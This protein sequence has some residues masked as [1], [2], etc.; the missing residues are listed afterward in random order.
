M[1]R[2]AAVPQLNQPLQHP[3]A[4]QQHY[5]NPV[6]PPVRANASPSFSDLPGLVCQNLWRGYQQRAEAIVAPGGT[7]I[8]DPKA[9]NRAINAAYARLWLEDQRFQWAG[10]AAFASK[11]VG[12]GLLHAADSIDKIQAEHEAGQ[13][14]LNS[15]KRRWK[16]PGLTFFGKTDKQAQRD[17]EHARSNNPVP[18]IDLRR[19]GESL[20]HWL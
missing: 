10:L 8:A 7:L 13:R 11:Q 12:C 5:T 6:I 19:D 2:K 3:G 1:R 18:G 4:I 14:M 9:R 16:F 17:Y 20:Y 15:A